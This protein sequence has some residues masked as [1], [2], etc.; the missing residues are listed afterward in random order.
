M[1]RFR[2]YAL[3]VTGAI[4]ACI[5]PGIGLVVGIVFGIWSLVVL[6]RPDVQ[7]AFERKKGQLQAGQA[8]DVIGSTIAMD[9]FAAVRQQVT[10]PAIG[11][12]ICAIVNCILLVPLLSLFVP[13]LVYR[14]SNTMMSG[15]HRFLIIALPCLAL[16]TI[17]IL[18]IGAAVR[19]RRLKCYRLAVFAAV[20]AILPITPAFLLS[21]P[22]GIWALAVLTDSQVKAAFKK[23]KHERSEV[24]G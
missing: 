20:L 9:S 16:V 11:M 19:M 6:T 5:T 3:A 10:G 14:A 22:I 2:S 4:L 8:E 24:S 1:L 18:L 23:N 21:L 13:R 7:A 12:V 15:A 17:V